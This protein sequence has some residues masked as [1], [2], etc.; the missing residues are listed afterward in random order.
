MLCAYGIRPS[1]TTPPSGRPCPTASRRTSSG[2]R[3]RPALREPAERQAALQRL[4][5]SR[6]HP[7]LSE[8]LLDEVYLQILPAE[9]WLVLTAP[10]KAKLYWVER[11]RSEDGVSRFTLSAKTTGLDLEGMDL[12]NFAPSFARPAASPTPNG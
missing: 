6:E 5:Q 11:P 4:R 12:S 2:G 7:T 1:A 9:S 3:Q 8:I 10:K